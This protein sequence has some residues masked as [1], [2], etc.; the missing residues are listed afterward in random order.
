MIS[1]N[2]QQSALSVENLSVF[3]RNTP[4]FRNVNF[5]VAPK[6]VTAIVGPS[7]IGKTTLL[8]CLNRLIEEDSDFRFAGKI[9]IDNIVYQSDLSS[10]YELRRRVGIVFQKPTIFPISI[11]DNVIFGLRHVNPQPKHAYPSIVKHCL[12]QTGLWDEVEHRLAD[13]ALKLSI[14]QQ[15]RLAIS[16]TIALAP[17]IILMDEPTSSLDLVSSKK[18]EDLIVRLKKN[19]A[20]VLVT[21]DMNQ[22]YNLSDQIISLRVSPAGAT[23]DISKPL[24]RC[25]NLR[26]LF[27]EN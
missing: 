15:Q 13:K 14:G 9:A 10:R 3:Y 11:F 24:I 27:K 16:R 5:E 23:A 25:S 22:A 20:V 19:H 12:E 4:I 6:T 17:S 21:H 18:V 8:R 7:G 1:S 2:I 26:P